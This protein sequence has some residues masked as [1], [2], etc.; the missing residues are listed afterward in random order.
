[1]SVT[2]LA[3][4]RPV[5][6]VTVFPFRSNVT[7]P[8]FFG[9]PKDAVMPALPMEKLS[10][11]RSVPLSMLNTVRIGSIHSSLMP[12]EPTSRRPSLKVSAPA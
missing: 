2:S 8:P 11:A 9:L 1:M 12:F 7:R 10:V 4:L 3:P 5:P 6:H